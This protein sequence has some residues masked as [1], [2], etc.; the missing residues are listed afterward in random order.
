VWRGCAVVLGVTLAVGCGSS[1]HG[2][3]GAIAVTQLAIE[4]Q[5]GA[6]AK[7]LRPSQATLHCDDTA[8]ATGFLRT[9]AGLACAFVHRGSIQ[10]VAADQRSRRACRQVY[11][12]PQSARII[13][14]IDSRRVDLT[15]TRT[16]GCGTADWQTLEPLLGD[17]QRPDVANATIA[18]RSTTVPPSTYLV[19]RGDTLTVLARRFGVSIAAIVAVNHLANPD[20]LAE[21]QRL[22]IPPVPPI[23]FVITPAAA[24]GGT[25]FQ[26]EPTG[27]KPSEA[28]TFEIDT[29]AHKYT[30]PPH[31][32]SADGVVAATYH[33]SVGDLAGAYNV[34]AKGN[35][36]TTAHA[37]F[38]VNPDNTTPTDTSP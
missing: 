38:R 37:A 19:K 15:V 16:D 30:G 27:A 7:A 33:S 34:I 31:T 24:Q 12:G 36:G 14:T 2:G 32:A 22:V 18:P 17:P 21:G 1:R 10:Q 6:A 3:P 35:H 28:I 13:G 9:T 29:P 11:G 4:K 8:V 20:H 23:R 25:D 26:L 5:T